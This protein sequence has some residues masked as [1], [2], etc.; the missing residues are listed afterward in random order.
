MSGFFPT[1][2]QGFSGQ[3][4][5]VGLVNVNRCDDAF[6]CSLPR[7]GELVA[8]AGLLMITVSSVLLEV[9]LVRLRD[10][11]TNSNERFVCDAIDAFSDIFRA[12]GFTATEMIVALK[13]HLSR[14]RSTERSA[15][16]YPEARS[17]IDA[18]NARLITHA[19]NR[20][21][22]GVPRDRTEVT[23]R[24]SEMSR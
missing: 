7:R 8:H 18:R 4:G 11:P 16:K 9:A 17:A 5:R 1:H 20:Y 21:Y 3:S 12:D 6:I 19:I 24:E 14:V 15:G 23:G 13:Q 10:D 22:V 2:P